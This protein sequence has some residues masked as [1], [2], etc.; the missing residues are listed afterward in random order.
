MEIFKDRKLEVDQKVRVY[1][2]LHK[3]GMFSIVDMKTGLVCCYA[4]TC[5]IKD[6]TF[7]VSESGRE[8]VRK[9][10]QKLVHAWVR[11]IFQGADLEP[12]EYNTEYQ[13]NPYFHEGFTNSDGYII[14][15]A[16][17]AYM[18]NKKVFVRRDSND[19]STG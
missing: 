17:F 11:G 8:K 2:N 4:R 9:T 7:Y 12:Q 14:T 5:L 19:K 1:V 3:Q 10:K 13:Y 6:A 18:S 15:E 16:P